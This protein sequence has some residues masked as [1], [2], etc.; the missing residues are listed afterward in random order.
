MYILECK[1]LSK[2]YG[3][4]AALDGIDLN[5]EE[6][7]IIGLL[8]ENGS[9]K[10]TLLKLANGL[11]SPTAGSVSIAGESPGVNSKK[12]VSYLPDRTYLNNWMKVRDLAAF[13]EDFYGDFNRQKALDM[14]ESLG[15]DLNKR[16]KALS[17]G[18]Q[19]KVQLILV[20]ARE[21]RLYLLD[22]PIGGVDPAAREY[23]LNTIIKNYSKNAT[24]LLSTHLIQ[25]VERILDEVIFISKGKIVLHDSVDAIREEKGCSVDA[26]FRE[27]FKC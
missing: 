25:E 11:L 5:L 23:I 10:T 26:L 20:M 24:I 9:G 6:G 7:R 12:I 13:F 4:N 18:N 27:V 16:L 21:A 14:L 1:G 17:K 8:G 22:E 19:E 2:N 15:I 3:R